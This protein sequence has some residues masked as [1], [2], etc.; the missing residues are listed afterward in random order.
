MNGFEYSCDMGVSFSLLTDSQE[1]GAGPRDTMGR[2]TMYI[3]E[4]G[5]KRRPLG[6]SASDEVPVRTRE[7]NLS[8]LTRQSVDIARPA[9]VGRAIGEECQPRLGLAPILREDQGKSFVGEMQP[10]LDRRRGIRKWDSTLGSRRCSLRPQEVRGKHQKADQQKRGR[11]RRQD[12]YTA[13]G[14]SL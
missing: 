9:V 14:V 2:L 6:R 11:M 1:D 13:H 5:T 7:L 12:N 3:H 8:V 10:C 4:R